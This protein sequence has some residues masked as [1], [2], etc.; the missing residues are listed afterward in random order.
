MARKADMSLLPGGYSGFP[1]VFPDMQVAPPEALTKKKKFKARPAETGIPKRM[2]SESKIQ[3]QISGKAGWMK[4][5]QSRK[6]P[7]S[8]S[9][10]MRSI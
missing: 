2:S 9:P 3:R 8:K 1:D 6:I 7:G 5:R 4:P 10:K